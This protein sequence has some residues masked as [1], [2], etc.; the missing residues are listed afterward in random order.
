MTVTI[1]LCTYNRCNSLARTLDSVIVLTLSSSVDWE[2]VVVD[3][4]SSDHTREV[5]EEFCRRNPKLFRYVFEPQQGK[6]FALNTGIRAA[7]GEILAFLDDDVTVETHWLEQL[8]ASLRG[9][10]WAGTGGKIL[11]DRPFS[12][13]SWMPF[14][15]PFGAAPTLA[16]LF[17]LG[18]EPCE[19]EEAPYGTNMAYRKTMF[20]KYGLFRTDLGPRPGCEIRNE[21]TEFGRRLLAAGERLLYEPSAVVYHPLPEGRLSRAYVLNW[22]FDHGRA[23]IRE[24]GKG[25]S[26]RGVPRGFSD[27]VKMTGRVLPSYAARWI[28]TVNQKERFRWKCAV[29]N[30][31]GQ[32][33][34]TF[35]MAGESDQM[36]TDY[37]PNISGSR[38]DQ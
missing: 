28:F 14:D 23:L 33:R 20:E 9:G 19:L 4:N 38:A 12:A 5:V 17:D 34:E 16:A 21:D 29:W 7:Q 2:V 37:I 36:R 32:I 15:S 8:T 6:S 31:A 10:E 30:T 22:W 24:K 35:R 25:P 13:P 11:L 3:N 18:N 27:V 26:I 1:I